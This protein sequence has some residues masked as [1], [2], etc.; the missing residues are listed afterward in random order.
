MSPEIYQPGTETSLRVKLWPSCCPFALHTI[1]T[2]CRK[3]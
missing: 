3:R 1:V 2:H